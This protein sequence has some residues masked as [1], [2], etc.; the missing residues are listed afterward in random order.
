MATY[1]G[2]VSLPTNSYDAWRAAT[3]GNGYDYDGYYGYQCWDFCQEFWVNVGSTLSTGGTGYAYGCWTAA[4]D[5]NAGDKF[6]LIT[7]LT[8]VKRG[9]VV[10]LNYTSSNEAGH[11]AFADEDYNGSTRMVLLGQN[12]VNASATTGHIVTATNM[13]VSNFLGAFRY[14]EWGGGST[15]SVGSRVGYTHRHRYP[16][17]LYAN[18]LRKSRKV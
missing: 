1:T 7:S 12:Q 16:W 8:D 17:V 18:K 6:D 15:P 11:I 14:K 13:N 2:F 4:R 5:A 9:D 10:V 3:I